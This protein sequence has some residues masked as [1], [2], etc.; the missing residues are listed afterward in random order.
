MSS[1]CLIAQFMLLNLKFEKPN[2]VKFSCKHFI[3]HIR[4]VK[5]LFW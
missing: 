2:G 5:L 3:T 1:D 4:R